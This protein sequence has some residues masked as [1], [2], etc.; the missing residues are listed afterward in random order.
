MYALLIEQYD[1]VVI[2]ENKEKLYQYILDYDS[3]DGTI[4]DVEN[5]IGSGSLEGYRILED[6]K[7]I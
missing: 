3:L 1:Q 2:S 7:S 4:E 6:C 5:C